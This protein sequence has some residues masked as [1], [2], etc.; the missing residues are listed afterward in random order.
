MSK[1]R[2]KVPLPEIK[3]RDEAEAVMTELAVWVNH[4]RKLTARRD[5]KVLAINQ[6]FEAGLT[7]CAENLAAKTDLLRA[8]AETNP[9]QFPKG[10]KSI[11][12]ANGTLGFRTGTPKLALLSRAWNWDK[13][14]DK[15]QSLIPAFIR[16]K[17]EVDKEAILGHE[18]TEVLI[19][20]LTGCGLK[21][22]QDESFFIEPALTETEARQSV[23]A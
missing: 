8:W 7:E 9:E 18:R 17:K 23:A 3:T 12:L 22:V 2:I 21:I 1:Q 15:V 16:T 13:V 6:E 10:L 5:A 14:L 20:S 11:K 19:N 4:Q